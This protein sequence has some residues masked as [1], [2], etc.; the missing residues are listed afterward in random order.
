MKTK[1]PKEIILNE[2]EKFPKLMVKNI[3][4]RIEIMEL[5]LDKIY[6]TETGNKKELE[7][8]YRRGK[9]LMNYGNYITAETIKEN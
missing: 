2:L 6:F 5:I 1:T 8:I 9:E 4:K 7:M 3:K